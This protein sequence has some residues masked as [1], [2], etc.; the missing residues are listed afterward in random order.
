MCFQSDFLFFPCENEHCCAKQNRMNNDLECLLKH[1]C[2]CRAWSGRVWTGNGRL[3]FSSVIFI[4]YLR[5]TW[6]LLLD[7]RI[8]ESQEVFCGSDLVQRCSAG[9][10]L[11]F[12]NYLR[13][14]QNP[15]WGVEKEVVSGEE[16]GHKDW[17]LHICVLK[18]NGGQKSGDLCMGCNCL[19]HS[20]SPSYPWGNPPHMSSFGFFQTRLW[21][22]EGWEYD[23]GRT[24][25][26]PPEV[27]HWSMWKTHYLIA[28]ILHCMRTGCVCHL[29]A[30]SI[31]IWTCH[32][33]ILFR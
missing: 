32:P 24:E 21:G 25:V 4:A 14:A 23:D 8:S 1:K 26:I 33:V 11:V 20:R 15:S 16:A 31:F 28:L 9:I 10:V 30:W 13:R 5:L 6:R 22:R 7:W 17:R 12:G 18:S 29:V 27:S 2:P 19:I 3:L